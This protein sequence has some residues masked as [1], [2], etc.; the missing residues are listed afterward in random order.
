M[1]LYFISPG[2]QDLRMWYMN[3]QD[4]DITKMDRL[5]IGYNDSYEMRSEFISRKYFSDDPAKLETIIKE[6]KQKRAME[7]YKNM[8]K[9]MKHLSDEQCDRNAAIKHDSIDAPF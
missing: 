3:I 1:K 7:A 8:I 2:P 4:Q 5:N 9:E 6:R